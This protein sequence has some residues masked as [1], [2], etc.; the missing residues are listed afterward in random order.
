MAQPNAPPEPRPTYP[1]FAPSTQPQ[2]PSTP[3]DD[4]PIPSPPPDTPPIAVPATAP[5][6]VAS[7]PG[8]AEFEAQVKARRDAAAAIAARL[9]Q[10]AN[11]GPSQSAPPAAQP[12]EPTQRDSNDRPDP[13]GFAARLMAKWGHKTGQGLGVNATGMVQ[14]L[15]VEQT[16]RPKGN[17]SGSAGGFGSKDGGNMGRIIDANA[18]ARQKEELEKFGEPSRVVV[19]SNM[20][21]VEDIGDEELPDEVA[22]ECTKHGVVERVFVHGVY[23]APPSEEDSVRVFVKFSGPVGAYKTV[24][25]FDGRFFGGRTVRARYFDERLFES[26][27]FNSPL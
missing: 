22:Q 17:K 12:P 5:A 25:D 10:M 23:P 3:A 18:D 26:R 13:H 11:A 2:A 6:P 7:G 21:S 1:G 9:A 14:P 8:S 4:D 24:R 16:S 20:V 19:L 15:A 27:Q